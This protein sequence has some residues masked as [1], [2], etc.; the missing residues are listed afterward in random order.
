MVCFLSR[1]GKLKHRLIGMVVCSLSWWRGEW[2]GFTMGVVLQPIVSRL[3]LP[4][5][6]VTS[7]P[8]LIPPD[9]TPDH[10]GTPSLPGRNTL[11]NT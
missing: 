5:A 9:A 8:S 1:D 2:V 7:N 4:D 11:S 10:L 6:L 3:L